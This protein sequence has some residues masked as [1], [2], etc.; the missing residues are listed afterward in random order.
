MNHSFKIVSK[1]LV[2]IHR[3]FSFLICGYPFQYTFSWHEKF[4]ETAFV[5]HWY[6]LHTKSNQFYF[7]RRFVCNFG[8]IFQLVSRFGYHFYVCSAPQNVFLSQYFLIFSLSFWKFKF[9]VR[10]ITFWSEIVYVFFFSRF[11]YYW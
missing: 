10:L 9:C 4:H 2:Y 8:C 7:W 11:L 1:Y 3:R 5:R 6:K